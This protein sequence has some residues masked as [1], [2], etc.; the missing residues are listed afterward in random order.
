MRVGDPVFLAV[1][2]ANRDPAEFADP[3]RFDVER[4]PN[5]HL[6]FGWGLHFCLGAQLARLETQ[7]AIP[8]L[9]RRFPRLRLATDKISWQPIILGRSLVELPVAVD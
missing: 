7:I 2:A 6:G 8:K 1:A 4:E 9:F 5:R 3:D